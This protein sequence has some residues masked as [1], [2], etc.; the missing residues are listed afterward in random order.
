MAYREYI[1][2]RYVPIFGRKDEDTIQWDNGSSYEP[3]TVVLHEGNSYTSRQYVPAGVDIH[4]E[5][6]W[7]QTGNYNAQVEAYRADVARFDGRIASVEEGLDNVQEDIEANAN[8]IADLANLVDGA[9]T[10]RTC[11]NVQGTCVLVSADGK[12]FLIDAGTKYDNIDDAE[13]VRVW[14]AQ[15]LGTAKLS[16]FV[17]SHFHPDHVG[18]IDVVA[19]NFC[20]ADTR[21]YMQME[22]PSNST[23]ANLQYY[24]T[25][26]QVFTAAANRAGATA[27]TPVQGNVYEFGNVKMSFANCNTAYIPVYEAVQKSDNGYSKTDISINNYSLITR[28]EYAGSSYTNTGDVETPAQVQNIGNV[29]PSTFASYPHHGVNMMGY[30]EFFNKINANFWQITRSLDVQTGSMASIAQAVRWSYL[31]R[32]A[33]QIKMPVLFDNTQDMTCVMQDGSIVAITGNEFQIADARDND[34]NVPLISNVLPKA[35]VYVP[36]MSNNPFIIETYTL[37]DIIKEA[38]ELGKDVSFHFNGNVG[39]IKNMPAYTKAIEVFMWNAENSGIDDDM[40]S[41]PPFIYYTSGNPATV[42][43]GN[44]NAVMNMFTYS[45]SFVSNDFPNTQWKPAYPV[46]GSVRNVS[47]LN[48]REDANHEHDTATNANFARLFRNNSL[49]ANMEL[50][51]TGTSNVYTLNVPITRRATNQWSGNSNVSTTGWLFVDVRHE[52]N[53]NVIRLNTAKWVNFSGVEVGTVKLTGIV[54]P[55]SI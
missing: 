23:S 35:N 28:I 21:F 11:G 25:Q 43:L 48:I 52:V 31:M 19:D 13:S 32:Y 54:N 40:E 38:N 20:D 6:F 5:T 10:V 34:N 53:S 15:I 30:C 49:I 27:I 41:N 42:Y 50:T 3:L 46:A 16:A 45:T 4:D 29:Q 51:E 47:G 26:R 1:G 7:A 55:V 44:I 14:L 2:S 36:E 24:L 17:V 22:V 33:Y 12:H 8:A 9:M 39:Y 37:E 18:A